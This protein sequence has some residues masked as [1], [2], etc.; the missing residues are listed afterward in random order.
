[1]QADLQAMAVVHAS[2]VAPVIWT[3]LIEQLHAMAMTL[4]MLQC[5]Q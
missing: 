3:C 5:C 1:M 2:L 4:P